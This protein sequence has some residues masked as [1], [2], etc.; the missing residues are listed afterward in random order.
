MQKLTIAIPTYNRKDILEK[1]LDSITGA[2]K[3][4]DYKDLVQVFV[5][6]N[7]SDFQLDYFVEKYPAFHFYR[8]VCNIGACSN[9]ARCLEYCKTE[10][11]WVL[12]DDDKIED[13]CINTIFNTIEKN[14]NCCLI[15]FKSNLSLGGMNDCE[16][17]IAETA[18]LFS[19]LD[20]SNLLFIST[21]VVRVK[22]FRKYMEL[23]LDMN[24]NMF[25]Y[26]NAIPRILGKENTCIYR[27]EKRIVENLP[28]REGTVSW[29]RDMF[30]ANAASFAELFDTYDERR[31]AYKAMTKRTEEI[32]TRSARDIISRGPLMP[33]KDIDFSI[34]KILYAI[35]Y[36]SGTR[37][38]ETVKLYILSRWYK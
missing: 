36:N 15:N 7:C 25:H 29:S 5:I 33:L 2:L 1:Q 18:Q 8:N 22:Y 9:V 31:D 30:Y 11:C 28:P 4:S 21:N 13:D 19:H 23:I 24:H 34:M 12:G 16:K 32:K 10:W 27:S 20:Y 14:E 3:I 6:D 17:T 37:L 38:V 35:K 26:L